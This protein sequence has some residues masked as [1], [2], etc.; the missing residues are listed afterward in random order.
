M[1][2][3]DP[4]RQAGYNYQRMIPAPAHARNI[5]VHVGIPFDACGVALYDPFDATTAFLEE[6][7]KVAIW[8]SLSPP[9][10]IL[11]GMP[12]SETP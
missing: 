8:Q 11:H 12:K 10:A 3:N 6:I 9:T 5:F 4:D 7:D 1:P 2:R